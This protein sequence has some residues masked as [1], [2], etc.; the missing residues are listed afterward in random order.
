MLHIAEFL[1]LPYYLPQENYN[2]KA[3]APL[4]FSQIFLRA[5]NDLT[6]NGDVSMGGY[7]LLGD[8]FTDKLII[9][10]N[11]NKYENKNSQEVIYLDEDRDLP[12]V[13]TKKAYAIDQVKNEIL[14]LP[15]AKGKLVK[16]NQELAR[17]QL[18]EGA[19]QSNKLLKP[20]ILKILSA[21]KNYL[22]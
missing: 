12:L 16:E 17:L 22:F 19:L 21:L 8:G 20:W 14:L 15:S 2:E 6:V 10:N 11:F 5:Q 13:V 3:L 4:A 7:R 1:N 18:R 9:D